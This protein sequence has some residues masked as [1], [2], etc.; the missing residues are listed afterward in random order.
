MDRRR[1]AKKEGE[2]VTATPSHSLSGSDGGD[3]SASPGRK[4]KGAGRA[5][6]N[7]GGQA[8]G[9]PES[10][11]QRR[12]QREQDSVERQGE[13]RQRSN[14]KGHPD[15]RNQSAEARENG[16]PQDESGLAGDKKKGR[17]GRAPGSKAVSQE[18]I[19]ELD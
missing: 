18:Q 4:R 7:R 19:E 15:E 12:R 1:K 10:S 13:R 11:P 5:G 2:A 14:E 6:G 3:Q 9:S 8:G 16:G 17:S